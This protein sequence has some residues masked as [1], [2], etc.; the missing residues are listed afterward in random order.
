MSTGT[1]ASGYPFVIGY[2]GVRVPVDQ[3]SDHDDDD[4]DSSIGISWLTFNNSTSEVQ[5]CCTS[6]TFWA[7]LSLCGYL[8]ATQVHFFGYDV[9]LVTLT[10]TCRFF[11]VTYVA[12]GDGIIF[13]KFTVI[14]L[15]SI[16]CASIMCILV[17]LSH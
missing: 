1:R 7:N 8:L 16:S 14:L 4:H 13:T 6:L 15:R 10:L 3:P 11:Y 5:C 9:D 17:T 2:P 12:F